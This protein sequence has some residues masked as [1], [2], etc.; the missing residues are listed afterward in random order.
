[1]C[2]YFPYPGKVWLNGH[3]WAKRQLDHAGIGYTPLTN[4][5]AACDDADALQA[6]CDRFGPV[7][8]QAFVDRWM[9]VIPTPLTANPAVD[10]NRAVAAELAGSIVSSSRAGPARRTV[11]GSMSGT[12]RMRR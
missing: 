9:A 4:G 3:E 12:D 7:D 11:V 1:M 8:V 5:F 10:H 6:V 2:T